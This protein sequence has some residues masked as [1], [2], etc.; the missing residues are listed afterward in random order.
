M[1]HLLDGGIHLTDPLDEDFGHLVQGKLTRLG[2][3]CALQRSE[4]M[5]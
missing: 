3:R 4:A 1:A 5:E 2:V